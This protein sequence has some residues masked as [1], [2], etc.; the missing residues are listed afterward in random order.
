MIM[1]KLT[2]QI[3]SA[4]V[5]YGLFSKHD[6]ILIALSGGPDSVALFHLLNYL[7]PAYDLAIAAAHVD[8]GLR[9]EAADRKSVV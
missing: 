3:K 4:N 9:R 1:N 5:R 7:A 8:H 2:A 6:R